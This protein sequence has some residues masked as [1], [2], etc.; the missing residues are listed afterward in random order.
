MAN[1]YAVNREGP[2]RRLTFYFELY[3]TNTY[4]MNDK[5]RLV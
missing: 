5:A 4:H 2:F 1:L 3:K